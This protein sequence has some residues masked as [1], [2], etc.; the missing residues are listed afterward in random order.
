MN[1]NI[2]KNLFNNTNSINSNLIIRLSAFLFVFIFFAVNSPAQNSLRD[3]LNT[4]TDKPAP[5]KT[6]ESK[7]RNS[8]KAASNKNIHAP[9]KKSGDAIETKFDNGYFCHRRTLRRSLAQ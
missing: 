9:D 5:R 7:P 3:F 6:T 8:P 2:T 4:K 1:I